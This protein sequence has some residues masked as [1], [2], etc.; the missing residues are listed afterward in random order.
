MFGA[1]LP[2][3]L[4]FLLIGNEVLALRVSNGLIL[5]MLFAMGWRWAA[6]A[7]MSR[8]KTG[9]GLLAMGLVLVAITIALGG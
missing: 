1:A 3:I 4:P 2:I 7:N 8:V 5:A 9:L 6:F